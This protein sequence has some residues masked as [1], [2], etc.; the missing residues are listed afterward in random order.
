MRG[1]SGHNNKL[2]PMLATLSYLGRQITQLLYNRMPTSPDNSNGTATNI[3]HSPVLQTISCL[4]LFRLRVEPIPHPGLLMASRT[5]ADVIVSRRSLSPRMHTTQICT[6]GVN[7]LIMFFPNPSKFIHQRCHSWQSVYSTVVCS[8]AG[9][10]AYE[11]PSVGGC[12][13]AQVANILK[14]PSSPIDNPPCW[15]AAPAQSW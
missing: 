2:Q 7:L 14:H 4:S 15:L 10:F 1:W 9:Y 6:A 8:A 13:C 12:V 11:G 3:D 5:T